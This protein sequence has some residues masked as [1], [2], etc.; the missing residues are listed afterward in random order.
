MNESVDPTLMWSEIA[1]INVNLS[2]LKLVTVESLSLF[3]HF[4]IAFYY[5]PWT[6]N[7]N[8]LSGQ[9]GSRFWGAVSN[10]QISDF[11][12]LETFWLT[13]WVSVKHYPLC[14]SVGQV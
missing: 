9:T 10:N 14:L 3:N 7:D 6:A 2:Y 5:G 13:P 4:I 8:R 11:W 1:A 12:L